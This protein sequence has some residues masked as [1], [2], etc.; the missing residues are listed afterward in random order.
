MAQWYI[1]RGDTVAGPIDLAKLRELIANGQVLASDEVG[2]NSDGPWTAA[3]RTPL[4]VKQASESPANPEPASPKAVRRP[5]LE[6]R[7][8]PQV[9]AELTRTPSNEEAFRSISLRNVHAATIGAWLAIKSPAASCAAGLV[10][11]LFAVGSRGE[12]PQSGVAMVGYFVTIVAGL[13]LMRGVALLSRPKLRVWAVVGMGTAT[14]AAFFWVRN[15]G[16]FFRIWKND[17]GVEFFD[18]FS[19]ADPY[20][21]IHRHMTCYSPAFFYC[22][23]PMAGE[24]K[25]HGM[26]YERYGSDP[27][28]HRVWY[29]Y[30]EQISE[31][32][33][34]LRTD[35]RP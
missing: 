32:E 22:R 33:W 28:D 18:T 12:D 20:H 11:A 15:T 13:L 35:P 5:P 6:Q 23:G 8:E 14:L 29:W 16:E 19:R 9:P 30:G 34:H 1:R 25:P 31:G 4:F 17:S 24:T 10:L 7:E 27:T 21:P 3:R 2:P 26:W